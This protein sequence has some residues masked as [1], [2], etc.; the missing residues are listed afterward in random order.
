MAGLSSVLAGLEVSY[1]RYRGSYSR[2][3]TYTPVLLGMALADGGISGLF[4]QQACR[5]APFCRP[6][7]LSLWAT[8]VLGFYFHIRGVHRKPG[9]WR[10]PI[11]NMVIGPPIFPLCYLA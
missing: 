10:L 1:K 5:L 6:F 7:L 4:L 3:V 8:V 2:R 11:V 9:G